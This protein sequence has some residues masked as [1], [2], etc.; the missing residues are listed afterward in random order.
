MTQRMK[1]CFEAPLVNVSNTSIL[2][3][4]AKHWSRPVAA[5]HI[6]RPGRR[7][8]AGKEISKLLGSLAFENL[9][10]GSAV[11]TIAGFTRHDA[12]VKIKRTLLE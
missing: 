9:L 1:V 2:E 6:E 3:I 10:C 5:G 11:L 8:F 12:V 4:R 7:Q